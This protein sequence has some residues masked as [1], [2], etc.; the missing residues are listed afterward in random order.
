MAQQLERL[1]AVQVRCRG[2][3]FDMDGVLISSIGSVE[4]TWSKWATHHGLDPEQTIKVVHGRRAM[5]SLK[6]LRPDLDLEAEHR[7]IEDMEVED[8][9]GIETLGGVLKLLET[10]PDTY[11]TVV[12]SATN[13]LARVR[14][15]AGKIPVP[16][17]I[18]TADDVVNGKPDPEPY[19]KGAEIL[20]FAPQDCIVVE[21]AAS[22]VGAGKA[23]GS[24]VLATTFS[25]SIEQLKAADWVVESLEDVSLK[26]FGEEGIVLEFSPL[27][28]ELQ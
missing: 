26:S 23:A 9:E 8:T 11:W 10:L 25:H 1:P 18:V 28:R 14:L 2:L 21:D 7:W 5:E 12:T 24:R 19:R 4:R 22:G 13:R 27:K 6:M 3:L 20:G 15:A 17:K 16:A